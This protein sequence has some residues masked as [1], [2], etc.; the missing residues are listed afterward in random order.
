MKFQIS[1]FNGYFASS[2]III[3]IFF[4][5]FVDFNGAERVLYFVCFFTERCR[6][7]ESST[8]THCYAI[9]RML[10]KLKCER[11]F[12]PLDVASIQDNHLLKKKMNI[13]Q[14]IRQMPIPPLETRQSPRYLTER[15]DSRT[16]NEEDWIR[17]RNL[18]GVT[19]QCQSYHVEKIKVKPWGCFCN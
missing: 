14:H 18:V 10:Q 7:R 3:I 17:H 8:I 2:P 12:R 13:L 5:F 19:S 1:N 11:K 4:F 16:V 15:F 9:D 6:G